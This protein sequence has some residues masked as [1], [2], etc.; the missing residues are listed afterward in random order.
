MAQKKKRIWLRVL[1]VVLAVIFV[2]VAVLVTTVGIV[3][4]DELSTLS[5][6]E[7]LRDRDDDHEDGAL[8]TMKV[9]G[10]YYFADFLDQGGAS[11]DDELISFITSKITKGI[12]SMNLSVDDISC[13]SFTT[14]T[15]DGDRLFGRNYD[16]SKTNTCIVFTAPTDGR[17]ASVSTADLQF[18]GIDVNSNVEG[19][20]NKITCLAAPFVPLDGMNDAGVSC[21]IYMTYQGE[22]NS[23]YPTNQNTD[24]DDIT[25]TTM[26]R[27]ILDYADSVDEA[28][29]LVQRYDLHDS[30]NT[31]YHYMIADST[32]KSAVLEWVYGTDSTDNDGSKRTLN[33]IYNDDENFQVVTNFILTEGYY[34]DESTSEDDMFGLDRY[35]QITS[36]LSETNGVVSESQAM[37]ILQTV[38]RRSWRVNDGGTG[39][40]VHSVVYNLTDLTATF[41]SNE[42]YGDET[43]T[44]TYSFDSKN[45]TFMLS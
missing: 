23:A 34:E 32:G 10:D 19:L 38:G 29:E 13:S 28:I 45:G 33:V 44:Y 20:M 9:K 3:W 27:M 6:F 16:F 7:L 37:G 14:E 22:G 36:D 42:N 18:L 24:K 21:G 31:S 4:Y 43:A 11:S 1:I 2:L 5:N 39:I 30:A 26:L 12:I 35:N 25:S 15:E 8:Y 41:V 17:H 40:T